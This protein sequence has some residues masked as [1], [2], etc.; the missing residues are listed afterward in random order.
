LWAAAVWPVRIDLLVVA[1]RRAPAVG[2]TRQ[3]VEPAQGAH[4]LNQ[5]TMEIFRQHAVADP[6]YAAGTPIEHA[7]WV[8]WQTTLGVFG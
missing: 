4:Y 7:E 1:R 2:A 8:T 5:R 6:V 3:H